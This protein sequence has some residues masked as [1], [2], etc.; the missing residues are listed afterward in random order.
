ML[1]NTA[2][3]RE[4]QSSLHTTTSK[5]PTPSL[6]TQEKLYDLIREFN[7]LNEA[8]EILGS[9]LIGKVCFYKKMSMLF[10]VMGRKYLVSILRRTINKNFSISVRMMQQCFT[11]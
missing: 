5:R 6:F 9:D 1:K 7:I 4:E 10:T 2:V 11:K 3:L 8:A